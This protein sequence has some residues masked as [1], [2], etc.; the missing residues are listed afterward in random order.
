MIET[1]AL[2]TIDTSVDYI[3]EQPQV[4]QLATSKTRSVGS[5][6]LEYLRSIF[7]SMDV[8]VHG[9][10]RRITKMK[11]T[12]PIPPT[13]EIRQGATLRFLGFVDDDIDLESTH[14]GYYAGFFT[15]ISAFMIDLFFL[16]LALNIGL[17]F[18]TT[19]AQL[20]SH[21]WNDCSSVLLV[22]QHTSMD[23]IR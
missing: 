14:I 5:M 22:I 18:I 1:I 2:S 9:L 13:N 12:Q 16:G 17:W 11:R 7:V 3:A 19:S 23:I 10:F 8:L 6:V 20:L 4:I 21:R 15:R